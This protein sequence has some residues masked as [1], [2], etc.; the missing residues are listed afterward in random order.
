MN[1]QILTTVA[2]RHTVDEFDAELASRLRIKET[3]TR[4]VDDHYRPYVDYT[5]GR[6]I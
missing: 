1:N 6:D 4:D 3:R 5:P 2:L